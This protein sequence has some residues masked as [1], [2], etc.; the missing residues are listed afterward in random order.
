MSSD[1]FPCSLISTEVIDATC[2]CLMATVEESEKMDLDYA[3]IER[4]LL[5]EFGRSLTQVIDFA[6]RTQS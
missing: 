6:N 2:Q 5:L 4:A 1:R 3:G